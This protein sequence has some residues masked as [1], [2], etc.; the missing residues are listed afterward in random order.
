MGSR[1]LRRVRR[2][3]TQGPDGLPVTSKDFCLTESLP[4]ER[5][6]VPR[7]S[8]Q[9]RHRREA[10]WDGSAVSSVGREMLTKD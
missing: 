1:T 3:L 4:G 10:A 2:S 9:A 7:N 5:P 6:A 8:L